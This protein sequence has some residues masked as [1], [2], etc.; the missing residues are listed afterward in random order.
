MARARSI[1]PDPH[2]HARECVHAGSRSTRAR[3]RAAPRSRAPRSTRPGSLSAAH[4]SACPTRAIATASRVGSPACS[5]ARARPVRRPVAS[6]RPPA[7]RRMNPREC[8]NPRRAHVVAARLASASSQSSMILGA[9]ALRVSA[10]SKRMSARSTPGGASCESSL[11]IATARS[12][13]PA[14][15]WYVAERRRRWSA[16]VGSSG[17]SSAASSESSPAAAGAP[18]A[19]ACSAAVSSSEAIPASGPSAASARWRAR[20]SASVTT[21]ANLRCTAWRFQTGACS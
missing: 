11:S 21:S 2:Q 19:A 16:S 6:E 9:F 17:V 13:S 7:N 4:T 18:R 15:R 12:P 3:A 8:K 14:R 5:P 20:S 10:S 1:S